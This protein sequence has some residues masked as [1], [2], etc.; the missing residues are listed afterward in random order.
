[1]LLDRYGSPLKQVDNLLRRCLDFSWLS[2]ERDR[3]II[4]D[5]HGLV[6]IWTL[7]VIRDRFVCRFEMELRESELHEGY[8]PTYEPIRSISKP[9]QDSLAYDF[10]LSVSPKVFFG[11]LAAS[12]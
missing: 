9:E 11:S 4:V 5:L 7:P 12:P 6:R 1:M 10:Y 2:K 3:E 8:A